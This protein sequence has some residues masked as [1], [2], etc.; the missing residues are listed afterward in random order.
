Q[1]VVVIEHV[2]GL[3]GLDIG[4]KQIL[5][6]GG[7]AG[8]PRKVPAQYLVESGLGV[9]ATRVDRKASAL[10]G[11]AA[12]RFRQSAL[13]TDQVHQVCRVLAVVN[14]ERRVQPDLF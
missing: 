2:L 4:G 5:Q 8:A 11:K 9:D 13:V 10:G 7:P 6:L 1:E 12:L 14:R 3:L